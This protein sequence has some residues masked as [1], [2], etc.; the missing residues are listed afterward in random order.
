MAWAEWTSF[1]F[2]DALFWRS[3]TDEVAAVLE[4]VRERYQR[5]D[6][7]AGLVASQVVNM[8]GK[9]AK[10]SVTWKDFFSPRTAGGPRL[11]PEQQERFEAR[12]LMRTTRTV[13]NR[14]LST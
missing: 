7:L 5:F 9:T 2:D 6:M 14:R 10:K 12:P 13:R 3:T 11:T 4:R 1:G 8:A